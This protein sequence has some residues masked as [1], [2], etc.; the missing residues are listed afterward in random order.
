MYNTVA[1]NS[2]TEEVSMV[3]KIASLMAGADANARA[4]ALSALEAIGFHALR[5]LRL[6]SLLALGN[7]GWG[8]WELPGNSFGPMGTFRCCRPG[9]GGCRWVPDSL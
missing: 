2:P 3:D 6:C 9:A 4:G 5:A 1:F 7:Q 8:L